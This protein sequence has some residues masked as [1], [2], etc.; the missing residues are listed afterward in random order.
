M[1]KFGSCHVEESS[2]KFGSDQ[3]LNKIK[4]KKLRI[5]FFFKLPKLF[6]FK[7]KIKSI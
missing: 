3:Y 1:L 6:F 2:W 7:K 5:I 4:L